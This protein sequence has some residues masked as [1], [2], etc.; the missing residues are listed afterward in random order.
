MRKIRNLV[1]VALNHLDACLLACYKA[2]KT[3]SN[4]PVKPNLTTKTFVNN[5]I[6]VQIIQQKVTVTFPKMFS[7]ISKGGRHFN[8]LIVLI[9]SL[10]S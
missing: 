8:C 2:E 6:G 7:K 9:C 10:L 3:Q 5:K 4:L 1:V